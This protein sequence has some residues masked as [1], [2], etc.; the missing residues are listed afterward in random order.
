MKYVSNT[1]FTMKWHY[2]DEFKGL[3]LIT[4]R[5]IKH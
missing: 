1:I 2:A 5:K 3:R 4:I